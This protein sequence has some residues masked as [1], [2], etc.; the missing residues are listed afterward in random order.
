MTP[1]LAAVTMPTSTLLLLA[2]TV[3]SLRDGPRLGDWR[4]TRGAGA[5]SSPAAWL[6]FE[7]GRA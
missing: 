5:P 6:E 2:I 4:G 7:G 3:W 1:L